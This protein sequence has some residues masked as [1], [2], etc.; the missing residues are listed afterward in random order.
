MIEQ[1]YH[2]SFAIEFGKRHP[3]EKLMT[4]EEVRKE[5]AI[6]AYEGCPPIEPWIWFWNKAPTFAGTVLF[7]FQKNDF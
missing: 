4:E 6:I 3:K 2:L 5:I 1:N 7:L